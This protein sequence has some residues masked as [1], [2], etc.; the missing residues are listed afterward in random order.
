MPTLVSMIRGINVAGHRPLRM[1]RLRAILGTLGC[2]DVRTYLQSGNAVFGAKSG[3]EARAAA[4]IER[5]IREDTGYDVAVVVRT[6]ARMGRIL[7]RNPLPRRRGVDPA[8]LHATLLASAPGKGADLGDL[9]VSRGE[10]AELLGDTVYLY[11]PNGY[12]NTRLSNA[13]W[14]KRLGRRATTRNW[15]TIRALEAMAAGKEAP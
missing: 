9:P 10:M 8:F 7:S 1:D 11:C 6:A 2:S 13:F 15:Q 3:D 5:A 12:G 4:A 14:E